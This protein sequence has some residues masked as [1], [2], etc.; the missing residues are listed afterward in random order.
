MAPMAD[1]TDAPFRKIAKSFG[2]GLTFTQMISAKGVVTNNFNTLRLLA[3]DKQE[4]PIGVQI[5]GNDPKYLSLAVKELKQYRP[6][7]I[8][9]NC[10]CPASKVTKYNMGANI[11][12]DPLFLGKL[13]RSMTNASEGIPISVKI[14]LGKEKNKINVLET[15]KAA[16]DNGAAF[17]TIH[18]RSR[19]TG[20][21]EDPEWE[22][23][24]KV[25]ESLS[26]PVVGN[27]SLFTAKDAIKMKE[28]TG[29]DAVMI[30]RGALG[31]PFI[32]EH[33]NSYF[34][35]GIVSGEPSLEE[36]QKVAI[37]HL[38]LLTREYGEEIGTAKAKKN[39]IW[40]FMNSGGIYN[41]VTDV[42]D[43]RS[44]AEIE[45]FI[46]IH[47]EKIKNNEY[48]EDDLKRIKNLFLEKVIFWGDE[49]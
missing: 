18:A 29:C 35:N 34:D 2:A 33:Y 20:Y 15:A 12:G 3:Y 13:V 44:S 49:E 10:G 26:I 6:D 48:P 32:F 11:L 36:I 40:Y 7:V 1:I 46:R 22:W 45:E 9:L 19:T 17:V 24:R 30:A 25:K 28:E 41:L 37:T 8:D 38:N 4:K 21:A 31:N 39:I 43:S 14:R 27:G 47:I 23:I 16:E 42:L 5:L